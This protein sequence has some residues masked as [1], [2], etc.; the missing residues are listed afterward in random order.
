METIS[1]DVLIV[2]AG[3]SG[4]TAS[5]CLATHGVEAITLSRHRSTA[6]TPRAHIT[7]QRTM[8]IFRDL[9]IEDRMRAIGEPL[10]F[11]S[12]NVL[13]TSLAGMEI[14]RYRSYGTPSDRLSDYAAAS[15]CPPMN[16]PQHIMEPVLLEV[17]RERGADVRFYNELVSIEQTPE[18]VV[19]R[20][21]R[22]DTGEEYLIRAKYVIGADGGR[23]RVAEQLGF[24]FVGEAGLRG[25][26]NSWLEVDL[27]K[28]TAHRPGVIYWIAQ[29]GHEQWF[30]TA[31]WVNVRPWNEWSLLYPWDVARGL[32]SE[33]SVIERA[34]LTIGDPDLPI[35][36]KA[37]TTWQVNNVVATEYRKGRVFLA[38]DAAH[39][40][41]PTGGLGTNTSIQDSFNLA[42][43]LSYVLTGKA[44]EALLDTYNEERQ[45]VGWQVV[46]RAIK[47]WHNM[48]ALVEA[49]GFEPGQSLEDGW[50]ALDE[51]YSGA[52][53]ATGRRERLIEALRL[54]NY[55]S[56]AIGVDLGQ[57]YTSAAIIGDGTP[58]PEPVRDPEL[59]YQPTTH[60][61]AALPHAWLERD[62]EQLSSLDL[63][64]HGV[65]TLLVGVGGS[66][67]TEAAERVGKETGLNLNVRSVGLRCDYD[68]VWCEWAAARE[69][70]DQGA[71]LV[72]P[73]RFVA[74]RQE[75][76]PPDPE[77]ALRTALSRILAHDG[78]P[79]D[80]GCD[81]DRLR[82][83]TTA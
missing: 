73:D 37:I 33:E 6:H 44:G 40:H 58:F 16:A 9:G 56:N 78:H 77:Q 55:R 17:A 15:P 76:L 54:Q 49:L 63:T 21:L 53:R 60:P 82:E 46:Q 50:A 42:W 13:A 41:P 62:R 64:G 74:W 52:D 39:R 80:G 25:M 66:R 1:T 22:R 32:P 45:P 11:L 20:V 4:L 79:R 75:T 26:A 8:E 61:G 27:S 7:N 34:R 3:P 2:G 43:K 30:G 29:P 31:S 23:S 70:G 67:W 28:Y 57:R 36:V 19:A 10:S 68:D 51:L 14:A 38:G 35:R 65:F 72:R 12:N 18:A 59:Y 83:D 81:V 71:I 48:S 69:V 47:S 24:E 5:L